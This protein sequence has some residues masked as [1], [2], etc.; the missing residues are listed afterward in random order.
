MLLLRKLLFEEKTQTWL[1][2]LLLA[3]NVELSGAE[4]SPGAHEDMWSHAKA[5]EGVSVLDK[6]IFIGLGPLPLELL[7]R[8]KNTPFFG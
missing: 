5:P 2:S 7:F 6:S 8:G 3:W 4:W 1:T